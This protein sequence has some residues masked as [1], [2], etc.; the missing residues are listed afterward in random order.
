MKYWS[1]EGPNR[2]FGYAYSELVI[3]N[4]VMRNG[5][6]T[7]LYDSVEENANSDQQKWEMLSRHMDLTPCKYDSRDIFEECLERVNEYDYPIYRAENINKSQN[8]MIVIVKELEIEER[9][10]EASN[11]GLLS[12]DSGDLNQTK[13]ATSMFKTLEKF[14]LGIIA[15]F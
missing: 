12:N 4:Y 7:Q 2:E 13:G 1:P 11:G 15:R 14:I 8:N 9:E 10:N 5:S 6:L 3:R